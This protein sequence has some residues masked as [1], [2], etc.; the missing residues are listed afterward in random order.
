MEESLEGFQEPQ[1]LPQEILALENFKVFLN[2]CSFHPKL[3]QFMSFLLYAHLT[4]IT[5][6]YCMN[7]YFRV[8]CCTQILLFILKTFSKLVIKKLKDLIESY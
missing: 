1:S 7:N 5:V 8:H 2:K 3:V 4:I 6:S